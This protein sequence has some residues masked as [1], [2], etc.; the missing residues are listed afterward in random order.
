MSGRK[1]VVQSD[2][3][4]SVGDLWLVLRVKACVQQDTKIYIHNDL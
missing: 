2:G 4:R 3:N 1:A